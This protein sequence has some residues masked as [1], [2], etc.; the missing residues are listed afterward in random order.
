VW[1]ER[2]SGL[3]NVISN[4]CKTYES[5]L[6]LLEKEDSSAQESINARCFPPEP[7]I[8][9]ATAYKSMIY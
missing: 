5:P 1:D 6:S 4:V 3:N 9:M 7:S 8:I 2:I